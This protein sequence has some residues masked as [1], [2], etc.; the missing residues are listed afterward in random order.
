MNVRMH[1]KSI[2]NIYLDLNIEKSKE[3]FNKICKEMK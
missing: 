2:K 1:E 3:L